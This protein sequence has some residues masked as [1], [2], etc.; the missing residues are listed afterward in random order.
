MKNSFLYIFLFFIFITPF[1]GVLASEDEPV[2]MDCHS[3][4]DE[5]FKHSGLSCTECHKGYADFP[6]EDKIKPD[7]LNCHLR[8]P[9][10]KAHDL[11]INVPCQ[12]CHL[13][14]ITPQKKL[15]NNKAEWAFLTADKSEYDPHKL[16]VP[17]DQ[18]CTR[19]HFKGNSFG[20]PG[21]KLPAK[22]VICMPCHSAAFSVNDPLS[23]TALIIFLIGISGTAVIWMSAGG[24]HGKNIH[25]DPS[26]VMRILHALIF[27]VMFQRRLFKTSLRR[28]AIHALIL[29]PF[30]ARFIWGAAALI[31][32]LAYAEGNVT[33]QM[34]DKNNPASGLFFDVTGLIIL[35]GGFLMMLDKM[36]FKRKNSIRGLP[37][38]S[39]VIKVL[40]GAI[41]ITGFITEGARIA[42][43]GYPEGSRYAFIGYLIGRAFQEIQLN[44]IYVY[45]WYLHAVLTAAFIAFLPFSRMFHIFTAPVSMLIKGASEDD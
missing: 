16:V 43:T 22:S 21:S 40:L 32:S 33:W 29:F 12:A 26:K 41:I 8:H 36:A 27:D 24:S 19:C 34:L 7:C 37:E 28:W 31:L 17:D 45:L 23:V 13:E 10:K 44:G 6:H 35:L 4:L 11:H 3:V 38:G 20:A 25:P 39:P 15:E 42:M 14:G 30:A 2:C 1:K 9:E 18:G 5:N